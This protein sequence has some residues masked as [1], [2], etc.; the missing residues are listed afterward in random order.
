MAGPVAG[1]QTIGPLVKLIPYPAA[2]FTADVSMLDTDNHQTPARFIAA[3]TAGTLS[4]VDGSGTTRTYTVD[5]LWER[6]MLVREI[7]LATDVDIEVGY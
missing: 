5:E 4:L 2:T 3:R 6:V 7:K 1:P